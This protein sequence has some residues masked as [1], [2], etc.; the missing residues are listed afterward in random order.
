MTVQLEV[1]RLMAGGVVD[2]VVAVIGSGDV[3]V[4]GGYG[5]KCRLVAWFQYKFLHIPFRAFC[6]CLM[7]F[8]LVQ[9]F[10]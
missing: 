9:H 10:N 8:A 3:G 5:Q 2:V 6:V 1:G 7:N 4:G